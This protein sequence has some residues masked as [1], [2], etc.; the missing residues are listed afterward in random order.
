[1]SQDRQR[2][3]LFDRLSKAQSELAQAPED[4][5][6]R[7]KVAAIAAEIG[8]LDQAW[9]VLETGLKEEP[10][11]APLRMA[12]IQAACAKGDVEAMVA[13]VD[14]LPIEDSPV[15]TVQRTR[16]KASFA[17]GSSI[18]RPDL[19]A[20]WL[21]E[22]AQKYPIVDEGFYELLLTAQLFSG[23]DEASFA[24]AAFLLEGGSNSLTALVTLCR[25]SL[26]KKEW[27]A[28]V[29]TIGELPEPLLEVPEIQATLA[30]AFVQGGDEEQAQA[31]KEK[32]LA[33]TP[34]RFDETSLADFV[35]YIQ[36]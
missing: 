21:A 8:D 10:E 27:Q 24:T 26:R 3:K 31:A 28:V 33:A 16:L 12:A 17:M 9:R 11:A 30:A 1:M 35:N 18:G 5:E 4:H 6:Q 7:I 22:C 29:K 23:M 34:A 25:F 2:K 14:A 13:Q 19:A 15:N 20:K 36:E 32:A